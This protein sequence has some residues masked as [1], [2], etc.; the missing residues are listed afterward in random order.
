[1]SKLSYANQYIE[2]NKLSTYDKP[3]SNQ[4]GVERRRTSYLT[5]AP[6]KNNFLF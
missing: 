5:Q 1:M 2:P 3:T 4:K 6:P